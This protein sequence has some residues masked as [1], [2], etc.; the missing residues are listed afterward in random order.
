MP[1]VGFFYRNGYRHKGRVSTTTEKYSGRIANNKIDVVTDEIVGC[2]IGDRSGESTKALWRSLPP[3]YRQCGLFYSDFWV[4]NPVALP[5]NRHRPVDKKTAKTSHIE[6][7]NC[8]LRQRV[9]R[10]VRKTLSLSFF[11]GISANFSPWRPACGDVAI[12][13]RIIFPDFI[14]QFKLDRLLG[15]SLLDCQYLHLLANFY[16][17]VLFQ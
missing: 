17:D 10:L 12:A 15:L 4:S 2:Y 16:L 11:L 7:F 8:T 6:R 14:P 9:S 1:E 5:S 13:C 3:V